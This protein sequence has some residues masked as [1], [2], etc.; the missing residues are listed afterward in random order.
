MTPLD[1]VVPVLAIVA[2]V[3]LMTVGRFKRG[4]SAARS[5]PSTNDDSFARLDERIARLEQAVDVIAVEM[6]RVGESQRFL[7]RILAER[8][9]PA[10]Q[11]S[12]T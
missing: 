5:T 1:L 12:E 6:E 7:T 2:T 8:Q 10:S 4:S 3:A 9:P 11:S